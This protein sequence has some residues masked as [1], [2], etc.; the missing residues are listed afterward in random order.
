MSEFIVSGPHLVP[1]YHGKVARIVRA[2]EGDAFFKT[3]PSLKAR[4]GC[5]VF[6]MR[7]GGGITPLYVG[8]ATKSFGQECFTAHKLGKCNQILADYA[9]GSLVLF[10]FESPQG[11]KAPSYQIDL[12]ENF[13]IQSALSVNDELLNI[14]KTKQE[15]WSIRGIIRSNS[16]KPSKSAKTAS[17][18]L[19]L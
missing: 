7:S 4:T 13:L 5:Y 17:S 10:L 12:L 9:K 11:K 1:V 16:G 2:E 14:K 19:G 3:H 18:M 15:S 8:K 6:A